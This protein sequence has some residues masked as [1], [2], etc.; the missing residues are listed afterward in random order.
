MAVSKA[1]C[2]S[3]ALR[4]G[5]HVAEMMSEAGV[6]LAREN[7]EDLF[8]TAFAAVLDVRTG[9]LQYCCAG[10]E[11]P[12]V[13]APGSGEL[14]RLEAGGGPALCVLDGFAY[15]AA[16]HRLDRGGT[17]CLFTDGVSEATNAAGEF[18]GRDRLRATI[19]RERGATSA[20]ALGQA[21]ISDVAQFVGGAEAADDLTLLV[22]RW[23]A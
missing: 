17:L 15:V 23:N 16:E 9:Q 10:H 20:V 2:K 12:F 13:F 19:E 21:I 6:E 8:V 7:P 3:T 14:L 18:Y 4:R 11:A 22:L 5:Q 1:L